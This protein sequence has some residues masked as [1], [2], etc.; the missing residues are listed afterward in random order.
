MKTYPR[1]D[2]DDIDEA[3][4]RRG[5]YRG[6]SPQ[7]AGSQKNFLAIV[8]S[9]LLALL[10]GGFMFVVSPRT[11]APQ[12]A[13]SPSASSSST[14]TASPSPS[15][16]LSAVRVEVY[17]SS[18]PEGS[19]AAVTSA[20]EAAGYTVA[21]TDN[22]A[23]AYT[24]ESM[25]YFATGSSTEANALADLLALPYINQD[26]EAESGL[27]YLVLGSDFDSQN[28]PGATASPSQTALELY[29]YDP[30]SGTY[31]PD[32]AGSYIYDSASGTYQLAQ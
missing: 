17:N 4:A 16:N 10:L 9:G 30:A 25:V 28:L 26:F 31:L 29:S 12:A 27:I 1:D 20:L 8:F 6:A 13:S 15:L 22:W 18:A 3:G 5:A 14:A 32:P 2:F 21:L 23:G 19:A 11:A 7:V 24:S